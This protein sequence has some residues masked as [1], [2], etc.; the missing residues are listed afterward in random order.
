MHWGFNF[1]EEEKR[2]LKATEVW[3]SEKCDSAIV[4]DFLNSCAAKGVY[5]TKPTV[6]YPLRL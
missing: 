5:A 4:E 1:Q 3:S 2:R 6:E